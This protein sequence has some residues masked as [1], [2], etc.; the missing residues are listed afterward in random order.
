L[1]NLRACSGACG[2]DGRVVAANPGIDGE[3]RM[4]ELAGRAGDWHYFVRSEGREADQR[5]ADRF[6]VDPARA[7]AE[8][9]IEAQLAAAEALRRVEEIVDGAD[10]PLRWRQ[11]GGT[12]EGVDVPGKERPVVVSDQLHLVNRRIERGQLQGGGYRG[13]QALE[14]AAKL[15][16]HGVNKIVG[17]GEAS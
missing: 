4:G 13:Q 16:M 17:P 3:A 10:H 11:I 2:S 5:V 7:A 6:D 15:G 8:N 9:R 12:G 1:A 14:A